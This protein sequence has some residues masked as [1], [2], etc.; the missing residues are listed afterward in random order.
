[1]SLIQRVDNGDLLLPINGKSHQTR[2]PGHLSCHGGKTEP[3]RK[4]L[5]APARIARSPGPRGTAPC[6]SRETCRRAVVASRPSRMFP[7]QPSALWRGVGCM[8][9]SPARPASR[10]ARCRAAVA[11]R[12]SRMSP[13]RP[14]RPRR[15]VRRKGHCPLPLEEVA[16][17][18]DGVQ[19]GFDVAAEKI[20]KG[21]AFAAWT[22]R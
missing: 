19:T 2:E 9:S 20:K 1:M 16:G 8:G 15:A 17:L 13:E 7:E 21:G 10:E 18:D 6:A 12:P 4:Y 22:N 11:S 14:A 3:T 5:C